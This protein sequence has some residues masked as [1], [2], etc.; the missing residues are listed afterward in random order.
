MNSY[1]FATLVGGLSAGAL[2]IL[3]AFISWGLRG[4][5]PLVILRSV[6]SGLLGRSAYQGGLPTAAL[7]AGLHF[8][9]T[10]VM[11]GFF[12]ALAAR[13]RIGARSPLWA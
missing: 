6:A 11:A 1:L 7:G 12:V 13:S 8:A 4:V 3:Y 9:M 10:C 5:S 2:D